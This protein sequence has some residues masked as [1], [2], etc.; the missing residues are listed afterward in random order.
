MKD[1]DEI[2]KYIADT[3]GIDE[4]S[5]RIVDRGVIEK[6]EE[7][8]QITM[9]DILEEVFGDIAKK[10]DTKEARIAELL[11]DS[12][13]TIA[14]KFGIYLITTAIDSF[15]DLKELENTNSYEVINCYLNTLIETSPL[16]LKIKSFEHIWSNIFFF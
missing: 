10:S 13:E 16:D 3:L 9:Q 12:E 15:L 5:I 14:V 8:E 2:K 11:V 7:P 1:H 4:D 6:K